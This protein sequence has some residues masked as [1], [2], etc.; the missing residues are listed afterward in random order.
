MIARL[1]L[2]AQILDV[3]VGTQ[4][5]RVVCHQPVG[6]TTV[7]TQLVPSLRVAPFLSAS[8]GPVCNPWLFD[9]GM[10]SLVACAHEDYKGA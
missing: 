6:S 7:L 10:V 2:C 3:L 9:F 8:L 5:V 1:T 4:S